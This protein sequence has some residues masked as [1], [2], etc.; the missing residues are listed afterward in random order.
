M[1]GQPIKTLAVDPG[2]QAAADLDI[3]AGQ[4]G[5]AFHDKGVIGVQPGA[6]ADIGVKEDLIPVEVD[7]GGDEGASTTRMPIF[8]T[9]VTR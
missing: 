1:F 3:G 6:V 2:A 7:I 9:G 4:I 8:S 5:R